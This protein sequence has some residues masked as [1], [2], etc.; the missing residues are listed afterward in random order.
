MR[1]PHR[2]VYAAVVLLAALGPVAAGATGTVATAGARP[3]ADAIAPA[4]GRPIAPAHGR[5]AASAA[6]RPGV[7][8]PAATAANVVAYLNTISGAHTVS[9][10]HNREPNA[11]PALWTGKVHDITG[12]YPGLWGGD[13]LYSQDDIALRSTMVAEAR[14]ERNAGSLVALMWHMCPPTMSEPCG[15]ESGVESHLTDNQWSELVTNGTALNNAWKARLDAIVPYLQGL[16]DAGVPVL[17]RVLHEM[18]D[19]WAWWGGR[20]GPGGSAKLYQ[21]THDYLVGTKGLTNLIW[22]WNVKDLNPGTIASYYPGASYV[23]VATLDSWN[24]AFP[25]SQYY[26]TMQS[27]APGKPIAL[28]E[29]GRLPTP[30]QLAAQPKWTYFMVWA[31]YLTNDN[32]DDA[33]KAT[34]YDYQVLHR[35]DI[36]L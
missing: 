12:V 1:L 26:Q 4:H 10:Q 32:S 31:E 16:K 29:V 30:A 22:V 34:Y 18:N 27:V 9:G 2:T 6:L 23:D 21:I 17:W 14:N 20:P 15:W 33:I 11:S 8:R 36:H 19:G 13:F 7:V 28:A 3:V 25:P 35:G 24:N 5:S